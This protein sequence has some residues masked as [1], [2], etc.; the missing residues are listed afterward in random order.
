MIESCHDDFKVMYMNMS[1]FYFQVFLSLILK[2]FSCFVNFSAVLSMVC[3]KVIYVP[4]GVI[5]VT[6][7]KKGIF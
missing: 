7:H 3:C 2:S 4:L 1:F 5:N 6:L